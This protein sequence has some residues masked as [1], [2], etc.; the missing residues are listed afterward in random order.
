MIDPL[1]ELLLLIM[2]WLLLTEKPLLNRV[3][4]LALAQY[5]MLL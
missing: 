5:P 2:K 3:G 4:V 1:R